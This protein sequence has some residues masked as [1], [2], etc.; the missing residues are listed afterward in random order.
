MNVDLFSRSAKES[1]TVFLNALEQI[2]YI[3]E[4]KEAVNKAIKFVNF[5]HSNQ[6]RKSGE[7]YVNHLFAVG[8]E[9][10]TLK[11]P[12]F[13]VIAA[14]M[15]DALEDTDTTFSEIEENFGLKIAKIVKS[16]SKSLIEN[17][18][19]ADTQTHLSVFKGSIENPY[20]LIIKLIDRLHNIKTIDSL[21]E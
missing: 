2:E 1:Q 21:S 7:P 5:K 16:L 12:F 6:F 3:E 18:Q 14:L 15:H 17:K 19:E 11:L 10:L 20:V 4:Q 13:V 8:T 9:C